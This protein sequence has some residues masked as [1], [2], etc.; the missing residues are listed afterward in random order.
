MPF[1]QN[2][3]ECFL[4]I[5]CDADDHQSCRAQSPQKHFQVDL[6]VFRPVLITGTQSEQDPSSLLPDT[7]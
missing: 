1:A 5:V 6:D 2:R 3:P 7:G 4:F